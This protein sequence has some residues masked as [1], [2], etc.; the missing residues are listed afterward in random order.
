[1]YNKLVRDNIPDIIKSRGGDPITRILDD[2]EYRLEL[3][4]KLLEEAN[5]VINASGDDR[6][7]EL[8]DLL[9]VMYALM[10]LENK[11]LEDV[12][13]V[14]ENKALKRGAFTKRLYLEN[15]IE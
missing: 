13:V 5:E 4:K 2:T 6:I 7:E 8:A 3:E 10:D 15:V 1:M 9:E 11:S 14:R 12:Q